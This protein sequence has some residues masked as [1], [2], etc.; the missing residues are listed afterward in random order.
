MWSTIDQIFLL[1]QTLEKTYEFEID[2]HHLFIDFKSAYDCV[3]RSA[4]Y[5]AMA[6]LDIPSQL[7]TLVKA[8]LSKVE[9]KVKVQNRVSRSFQTHTGLRQGDSLSC[10]LFNIAL[11]R[12]IEKLGIPTR[13]TIINRSVQI[14]AY[15]DDIDNSNTDKKRPNTGF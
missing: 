4:L 8:T 1:R 6:E 3:D 2:T 10:L 13:G 9:C 11:E 12:A 14:L 15:A 5:N 7:I